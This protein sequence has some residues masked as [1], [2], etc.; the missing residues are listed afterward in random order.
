VSSLTVLKSWLTRRTVKFRVLALQVAVG[1]VFLAPLLSAQKKTFA[2]ANDVSFKIST[3]SKTYR[4]G[5]SITL[6]Y[7]VTNVSRAPLFVPREWEATC[8]ANPH[9]WAWFEDSSGKQFMPGYGV[10][11]FLACKLSTNG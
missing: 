9:V 2:P 6:K 8:P 4:T 11:V 1:C 5:Q 3:A 10:R 7:R